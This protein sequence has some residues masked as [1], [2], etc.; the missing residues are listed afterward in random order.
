MEKKGVMTHGLRLE[1]RGEKD[2]EEKD[3]QENDGKEEVKFENGGSVAPAILRLPRT[4][5]LHGEG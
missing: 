1:V 2:R 3:R 5:I 4:S